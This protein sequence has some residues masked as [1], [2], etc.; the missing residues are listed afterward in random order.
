MFLRRT[1]CLLATL[2]I[3]SNAQSS[4]T[5][6]V[7]YGDDNRL[8][9]HD[10]EPYWQDKMRSTVALVEGFKLTENSNGDFEM[11]TSH[12]GNSYNLCTDQAFFDQQRGAFCS[13]SLIAPDIVMTAGHCIRTAGDCDKV[14]L[15]FDFLYEE[16]SVLS[17]TYT[18]D[19]VYSCKNIIKSY[20]NSHGADW[21]LIR[22]DRSVANRTPLEVRTEGIVEEGSELVVIG[23]PSGLPSKYADGG[24]VRDNS[25][26]SYFRT[27]LDTFG[28]NS[29]SA[30][31][32]KDTGIIEGI[33]VRGAR[34]YVNVGNCRKVNEC[35]ED[36]C[37]GEDVTRVD[38]VLD[39]IPQ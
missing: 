20:V 6:R 34:D 32:N 8:D 36:G 35:D 31:F 30:V 28:G 18:A 7:I 14:R 9:Y 13:G 38:Q 4:I 25:I 26:N 3:C 29:G 27:N 1:F 24:F 22:L 23:H 39:S 16:Y 33:L 19:Q 5:D 12:F 2:L 37:R 17:N 15:V 21:A 10:V 11:R